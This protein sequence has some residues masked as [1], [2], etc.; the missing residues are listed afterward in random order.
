M[1]ILVSDVYRINH[2]FYQRFKYTTHAEQS[3]ISKYKNKRNL[4]NCTLIII[5]INKDGY[6]IPCEPCRVC[7]KMIN[8]YKIKKVICIT[9]NT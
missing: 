1:I 2:V 9:E 6:V 8:K 5:R 3:C 4:K 7:Q